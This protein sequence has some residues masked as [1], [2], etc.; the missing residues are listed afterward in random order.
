MFT[1]LVETIGTVTSLV[2][3][4][5]STSGGN[6]T[7]LTI[8]DCGTIL[9]DAAL[10]DSICVNGT[11][12]TV[13]ELE[14]SQGPPPYTGFKVGVAP[15]TLRRTNLGSL[16]EGAKVNLERAV[17]ASTRM[18]GH[19]VQGHV[20]TVARIVSVTPDGN[21]L[22]FRLAPRD[23]AVL[24]YIVEKGYVTLDGASLTVTRVD[25]AQ[26][27]FEVMLIA[28]TQE[29]VV[30]AAKSSGDEVNVEIDIVGKLV[31]KSVVGYLEE[32]LGGEQQQR[33]AGAGAAGGGVP[34]MLEKIVGRL[35][36]EKLKTIQQR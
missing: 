8:S 21:A 18:G 23:A 32:N 26:G 5:P 4:D 28:Y 11:C 27:W 31:E 33:G 1:G 36:D 29:R 15:E 3:L 12:L 30:M 20:D 7:S 24:R 22:T 16:R 13:T 14:P 25:D 19:F 35:V 6:G 2:A 10:G 34:A 9:T 17:S